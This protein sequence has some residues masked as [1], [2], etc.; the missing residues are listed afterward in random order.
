MQKSIRKA[1]RKACKIVLEKRVLETHFF[2]AFTVHL[3][4]RLWARKINTQNGLDKNSRY[5][6]LD[7]RLA[8]TD[9]RLAPEIFA[10]DG[11]VASR[12]W[13][14]HIRTSAPSGRVEA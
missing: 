9:C 5:G 11:R 2:Y 13:A 14:L 1:Q 6:R 3:F 7:A 4:I 10:A 12:S 8:S